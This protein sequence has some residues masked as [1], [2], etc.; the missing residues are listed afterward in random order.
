MLIDLDN[1][2]TEIAN[3]NFIDNLQLGPVCKE[4]SALAGKCAGGLQK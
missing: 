2:P 4:L 1:D 3:F